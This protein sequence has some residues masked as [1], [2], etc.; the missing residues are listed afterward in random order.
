MTNEDRIFIERIE[1]AMQDRDTDG[2]RELIA[3]WDG[4]PTMSAAQYRE[5]FS[6]AR[7]R[8]WVAYLNEECEDLIRAIQAIDADEYWSLRSRV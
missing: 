4:R 2:M 8:D 1:T 7:R 3:E 5:A 6:G